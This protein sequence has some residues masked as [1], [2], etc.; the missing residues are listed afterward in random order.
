[1]EVWHWR[2]MGPSSHT[3]EETEPGYYVTVPPLPT[4]GD[5]V[6]YHRQVP[7][8]PALDDIP[9][10]VDPPLPPEARRDAPLDF[11]WNYE[12]NCY[13]VKWGNAGDLIRRFVIM[14][15]KATEP[16]PKELPADELTKIPANA[17]LVHSYHIP[18]L[19]KPEGCP[20]LNEAFLDTVEEPK[21]PDWLP[22]G[23][24]A[25]LAGL[26]KGTVPPDCCSQPFSSQK[27]GLHYQGTG[28]KPYMVQVDGQTGGVRIVGGVA[29]RC[30]GRF[31]AYDDEAKPLIQKPH[32]A[33]LWDECARSSPDTYRAAV[34]ESMLDKTP[35]YHVPRG[36]L[37]TQKEPTVFNPFP[38]DYQPPQ[39]PAIIA[40]LIQHF[41]DDWNKPRKDP[42]LT[43]RRYGT[44]EYFVVHGEDEA[45]YYDYDWVQQ[46]ANQGNL[47]FYATKRFHIMMEALSRGI[48]VQYVF[49]GESLKGRV[50][51]GDTCS[52][53]PIF[54]GTTDIRMGDIVF[55][56]AQPNDQLS[57]RLV[58][59]IFEAD[60]MY[61]AE[62]TWFA[63]GDDRLYKRWCHRRHIYG[64]LNKVIKSAEDKRWPPPGSEDE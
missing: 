42:T 8:L 4:Y 47:P 27:L 34:L 50:N 44:H 40:Q 23:R 38:C 49:Y 18:Q 11:Q 60:D 55:C 24:I 13:T 59:A 54:P 15:P 35:W 58:S 43:S 2:D 3:A 57:L 22:H 10:L 17:L 64:K 41:G 32:V 61:G 9:D 28:V 48:P 36:P 25:L 30:E 62:Q 20:Q 56:S 45:G 52:I 26:K 6:P 7:A 29:E 5:G 53:D 37:H 51:H 39:D 19:H 31:R 14:P 1:M 16:F 21:G 46:V 63:F 12:E 33:R